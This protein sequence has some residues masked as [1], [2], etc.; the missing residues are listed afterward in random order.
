M[1][2]ATDN[3]WIGWIGKMNLTTPLITYRNSWGP[4]T[5][6]C[7]TPAFNSFQLDLVP[8]KTTR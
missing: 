7:G 5:D 6:P 3:D 1:L 2:Y 4:K 8:F